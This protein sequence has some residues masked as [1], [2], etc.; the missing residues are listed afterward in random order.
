MARR[1]AHG[2]LPR[3]WARLAPTRTSRGCRMSFLTTRPPL[4]HPQYPPTLYQTHPQSCTTHTPTQTS[5]SP[6]PRHLSSATSTT[7]HSLL[8][9]LLMSLP[10]QHLLHLQ[11]TQIPSPH[12]LPP[13]SRTPPPQDDPCRLPL[14]SAFPHHRQDHRP[15][16]PALL[17]SST[18]CPP[19]SPLP[20]TPLTGQHPRQP[21]T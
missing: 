10:T 1:Q 18:T 16:Q 15:T 5:S 17:P 6:R 7:L 11:G 2:A 3:L 9:P 8:H 13:P 12:D 14:R 20:Q 19:T 4:M 21:L